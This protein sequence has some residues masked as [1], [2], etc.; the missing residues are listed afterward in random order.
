MHPKFIHLCTQSDYSIISGLNKPKELIQQAYKLN[1]PALGITDYGNFYGAIKF[2]TSA[3]EYG[4]KPIFGVKFKIKFNFISSLSLINIIALDTIGYRNLILL[5]SKSR[6]NFDPTSCIKEDI[7]I[8]QDWL[9]ECRKGL[10][11]L[12]GGYNG[13]FG[14]YIL[15]NNQ[16]IINEFI[17][18]YN[19]YFL[20]FYYFEIHRTNR[21][22][23]EE[24]IQSILKLSKIYEIPIVATNDVCFIHKR[25]FD[26]YKIKL[27][28][29][30]G[31]TLKKYTNHT[32]C[33]HEQFMKSEQEMCL[34]FSDIP[35]VLRNSIEIA[36][37]CNVS[38]P[39]GNYF[40]PIFSKENTDEKQLL[41]NISLNG[42]KNRL[43]VL[44]PD[45]K[46]RKLMEI[47]YRNRLH[48]ELDVINKMNFPGYFLIVMEF[49]KWAKKNDIPVGPGRGSGAGSLVA[50]SINITELDPLRFGLIFERFLN[51]E[52][53]SMP[54]F[55]I[56]FCM[57]KRDLVIEHVA[58]VY[59]KDRVAQI[60]TFGTMSARAVI[61]DVGRVL[62]YPYGFVNSISKLIPLDIGITLKQSLLKDLD[63]FN[64]YDKNIEV[65]RL[66]DISQRLE[67]VI[68][69]TGKHAGGIVISPSKL[70]KF[71]PVQCDDN[72]FITQFDKNDIDYIGLLKF[73]F[74]GLRTLTILHSAVRMI[75]KRL[76]YKNQK[77]IHLN[78]IS[79][80][81]KK[82]FE[83]LNTGNTIAVFQLE[84]Y[85]MRNL[86][87]RL[88]PDCFEDIIS[89]IALFRPGP[90]QSGM[91]DNFI[92]RKHGKEPISYPD[93]KW[94]HISLKPILESTYGI[95]LY[96]EQVMKIAQVLSGYSLSQAD[97]LQRA[98]SKKN[99]KE[100]SNQRI[101][102][103]K[104]AMINGISNLLSSKIFDLLEKFSGYGFNKSHSSAYALISYQTLWLKSN[105]PS[106][107]MASVMS[108]DIDNSDKIKILIYECRRMKIKIIPPDINISEYFFTVS[109]NNHIIYG[110]GAIKGLGK[111]VV[112]EI[113]L[114]RKKVKIFHSL[115]EFCINVSSQCINKRVLEKLIFSGSFDSFKV[116]REILFYS[117]S[118]AIQLSNQNKKLNN[119]CQ[120]TLLKPL[121]K[122][123]KI[124][125]IN[126]K[127]S[128]NLFWTNKKILCHER[129]VIG[130]YLTG[131]PI[132]EYLSELKY[133]T[134]GFRIRDIVISKKSKITIF[135]IISSI[136]MK[137]TKKKKNI[138]F[139][140]LIDHPDKVEVIIFD[141]I[142]KFYKKYLKK[143]N[144]V[145]IKGYVSKIDAFNSIKCIAHKIIDINYYRDKYVKKLVL[146]IKNHDIY[147]ALYNDIKNIITPFLG[148]KIPIYICNMISRPKSNFKL[149]CRWN[150][151][152]H[153]KLL[154]R[155]KFLLGKDSV[156]LMF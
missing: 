112:K 42:L 99:F 28:I 58:Q 54:D 21:I 113:I 52:R 2:Y 151:K 131:N 122:E 16:K 93:K 36:Q 78:H 149:H 41:I 127:K 49:V 108:A 123:N 63:F 76:K 22:Y 1:M 44:Y 23:E 61:R 35:E 105:Y 32:N 84:S 15:N 39:T 138:I 79:L 103:Q 125:S 145:I 20:D 102:F 106:E 40:L 121:E 110:L 80:Q 69:N 130:F 90:L 5:I 109:K 6:T 156:H 132:C 155:L 24:Y 139:L 14:K 60:I 153:Q 129:D 150:V 3:M 117:I 91:V 72:I 140:E 85:G 70:K 53:R 137:I 118:D 126:Y 81:D 120:L 98:M 114:S 13:D 71:T 59:G 111:N 8:Y 62:G 29:H 65:K 100:M 146:Y 31:V 10:L 38:I 73:D 18:F 88:Q 116:S 68:R 115:F 11:I 144:I 9:L 82:S 148:G 104:C 47:K 135:G 95:I 89:L 147:D 141:Y 87:L 119:I 51:H 7:I 55:D 57:E 152:I 77:L 136:S 92:N 17:N 48:E 37:R 25:D 142:E 4:I 34:L 86:I 134:N 46:I 45:S 83:L 64:L 33:S 56:D 67:G 94:Q 97:I 66:V 50:Y 26:I 74:L 133:Y 27:S 154:N 101:K 75:N 107:F 30:Q 128:K 43:N 12:S 124:L 96:Q 19:T 143:D